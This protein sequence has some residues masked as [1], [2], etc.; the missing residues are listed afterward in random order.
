MET[1]IS[2]WTQT[3][4]LTCKTMKSTGGDNGLLQ[5]GQITTNMEDGSNQAIIHTKSVLHHYYYKA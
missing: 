3:L 1:H 2:I 5:E 4:S